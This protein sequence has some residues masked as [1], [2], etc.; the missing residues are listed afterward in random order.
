M[1]KILKQFLSFIGIII[2]FV[3]IVRGGAYSNLFLL[4][5][6]LVSIYFGIVYEQRKKD[7]KETKFTT[8][9]YEKTEIQPT[10]PNI[11]Q[12]F[13]DEQEKFKQLNKAGG[14]E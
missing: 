4:I 10:S 3:A 8:T 14:F 1:K 12:E 7:K 11:P 6:I 9:K 13:K 2:C 5:L